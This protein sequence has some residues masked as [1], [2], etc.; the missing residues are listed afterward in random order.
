MAL[1]KFIITI[2]LVVDK[3]NIAKQLKYWCKIKG[4]TQQDV[5]D[6]LGVTRGNV[7]HYFTGRV[8]PPFE[9]IEKIASLL[10]ITIKDFLFFNGVSQENVSP[11][12][13]VEDST[14]EP[15]F[16]KG[17]ILYID[18]KLE[19][20]SGDFV[21]VESPSFE[22]P[23]MREYQSTAGK[24][25]LR[26]EMLEPQLFEPGMVITGVVTEVRIKLKNN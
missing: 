14:M 22:R 11:L 21:V 17:A 9:S 26:C 3:I 7:G 5:A 20:K 12:Y 13:L 16:P 15:R 10:K 24:I 23:I 2:S 25:Y 18:K 1:F 6:F 4:V 8:Y 19:P